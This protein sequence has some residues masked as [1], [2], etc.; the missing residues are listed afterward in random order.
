MHPFTIYSQ[1]CTGKMTLLVYSIYLTM[2]ALFLIFNLMKIENGSCKLCTK[3][4]TS[5][6][7]SSVLWPLSLLYIIAYACLKLFTQNYAVE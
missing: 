7:I 2:T 3:A 4:I 5:F 6:I 1:L